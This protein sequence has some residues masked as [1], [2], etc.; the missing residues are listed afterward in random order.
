MKTYTLEFLGDDDVWVFINRRLAVD[1]GASTRPQTGTI[2]IR[3]ANAATYGLTNGNVY[4]V[5][6]FQAERQTDSSWRTS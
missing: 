3:A 1:I 4:E 5:E 6:V 2:T